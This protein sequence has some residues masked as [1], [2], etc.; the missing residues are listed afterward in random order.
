M[1]TRPRA[2]IH[3]FVQRTLE[4]LVVFIMATVPLHALITTF[5]ID[6]YGM[7]IIVK[8]WKE[9]LLIL[10]S[11][12]IIWWSYRHK[13]LTATLAARP[14][15]RLILVYTVLHLVLA[16][17]LGREQDAVLAGLSFNLRFLWFFIL[18]QLVVES[19][20]KKDRLRQR[21][22]KLA[23]WGAGLVVLFGSLQVLVLPKDFLTSLGY[24]SLTILPYYTID[25]NEEFI[26][27]NST[28]RGPNPL[29]AYLVLVVVGLA[30]WAIA[31]G[32]SVLKNYHW[33]GFTIFT[34]ITFY[35]S[36]SRS[37]WL[38]AAVALVWLVGSILLRSKYKRKVISGGLALA[39]LA[40]VGISFFY[41]S[42]FVQNV[43]FHTDPSE[44]SSLDSDDVRQSAISRSWQKVVK[45]PIGD[46]PGA[47][48]P[49]SFY[50][51]S[52]DIPENYY[53][54]LAREVGWV[55][56]LMFLLILWQVAK[57]LYRQQNELVPRTLLASLIGLLAVGLLQHVWTD[58]T[59]AY[60][61]WGLC[62][63]WFK[64][65]E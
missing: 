24:N 38:G 30:A 22:L 25:G 54:Q 46:G 9:I 56:L 26:R 14:V 57:E 18:A 10:A 12:L 37:G 44:S 21:A 48:G 29:G 7:E 15:N 59:L 49:A 1:P 40:V 6:R 51:E 52:A 43:I 55:G 17:W 64:S 61:W 2:A 3:N 16:L 27:I 50:A 58:D 33:L 4:N 42:D 41:R 65:S 34:L 5:I 23:M 36:H 11:P 35:G 62:G 47:A 63:L 53:L 20:K 13:Q 8:S 31:K 32:K 19:S 45:E 28:L 60:I 39:L